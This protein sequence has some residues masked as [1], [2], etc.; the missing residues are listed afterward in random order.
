MGSGEKSSP[1]QQ[2]IGILVC[3]QSRGMCALSSPPF[4]HHF[5][6]PGDLPE[7]QPLHQP[8]SPQE[9]GETRKR[10]LLGASEE[11]PP[12]QHL[13]LGLLACCFNHSAFGIVL[14]ATLEN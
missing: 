10:S 3:L 6:G 1:S 2:E 5:H 7:L 11:V 4:C 14:M 8:Y 9:G 13:A 12:S